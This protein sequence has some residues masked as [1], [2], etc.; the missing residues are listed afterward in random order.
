MASVHGC[1]VYSRY[2]RSEK[3]GVGETARSKRLK[4][5]FSSTTKHGY[6]LEIIIIAIRRCV[7]RHVL[8]SQWQSG[9]VAGESRAWRYTH[10]LRSSL[11]SEYYYYYLRL[12]RRTEFPTGVALQLRTA[13][14][15][16]IG[17]INNEKHF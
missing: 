12:D 10:L 11:R 15:P 4:Q 17:S 5:R 6:E 2:E 16:Q 9:L 14:R 8:D 1:R 3:N 7:Y 13:D